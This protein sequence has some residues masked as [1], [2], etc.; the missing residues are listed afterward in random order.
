MASPEDK[1]KHS[2]RIKRKVKERVQ[3]AIAKEISSK[4]YK[5]RIIEDKKGRKHDLKNMTF[6]DL[7]DAIQE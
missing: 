5:Q 2:R 1:A 4:K 7:V 6:L 3:S